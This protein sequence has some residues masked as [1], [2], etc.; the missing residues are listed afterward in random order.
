MVLRPPKSAI[1]KGPVGLLFGPVELLSYSYK[2]LQRSYT[3]PVRSPKAPCRP[4]ALLHMEP[5]GFQRGRWADIPADASRFL[6]THMA[7]W[8]ACDYS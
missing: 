1:Y 8:S 3:A 5:T 2:V 7:S 4:A 6:K